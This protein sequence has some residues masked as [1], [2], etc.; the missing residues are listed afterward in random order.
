VKFVDDSA[1]DL[2]EAS[3]CGVKRFLAQRDLEGTFE[4]VEAFFFTAVMCSGPPPEGM[5]PSMMK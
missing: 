2:Y 3:G 1:R 5:I 4:E